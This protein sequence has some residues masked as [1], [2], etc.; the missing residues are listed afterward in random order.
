[1]IDQRGRAVILDFGLARAVSLGASGKASEPRSIDAGAPLSASESDPLSDQLTQEGALLGTPAYIPPE[2]YLGHAEDARGDQY[3]LCVALWEA[4]YGERPFQ[5]KRLG[6]LR[7]LILKGDPSPPADARVIPRWLRALLRRGLSV[8]RDARFPDVH[9][10]IAALER[11]RVRQ[12]RR[13]L[14]LVS[15]PMAL[16]LLGYL[17]YLLIQPGEV[18]LR[19]SWRG[20]PY[21]PAR[22]LVDGAPAD[23]PGGAL[24]LRPGLHRVTIDDPGFLPAEAIADVSA[25]ARHELA[26]TLQH[27][28]AIFELDVEPTG[29]SVFVDDV[30]YGSRL[31]NFA[32]DTGEHAIRVSKEGHY[33]QRFA[34]RAVAGE[35]H[36]RFVSLTRAVAWSRPVTGVNLDLRWLGDINGDGLDDLVI[37]AG[38]EVTYALNRNAEVF[39]QERTLTSSMVDGGAIPDRLA[40]TTVLFADMNGNGS[41]DVVWVTPGGQVTYLELFPV[42]PNLLSRVENGVG[43]VT[44]V[45]YGTSVEHMARDGGADAWPHRLPHPMIVV[46]GIDKWDRLTNVHEV[47][48]YRYH[49]GFYDGVEKRFRGYGRV[50]T[51]LLSD[52]TQEGGLTLEVYDVGADDP[53]RRGRLLSSTSWSA[54][55]ELSHSET[56]WDDCPVTGVAGA[57]PFASR[58]VCATATRSVQKEGTPEDRWA[59][60]ETAM[61][62]DGYGNVTLASD[63]GVTSI[64]GGG[65]APCERDDGVYGAPCGQD[66]HGDERFIETAYVSPDHTHGRWIVHAPY[67]V[68]RYG[69]A[70]D[71]L[72]SEVRTYYDGE[73]F[74]G[75]PLGELDRGEITRTTAKVDDAGAVISLRRF[76]Y[77]ADGNV[78]EA[79]DPLADPSGVTHRRAYT[80]D[81]DHLRVVAT[82]LLL[83]D[84]DGAPYRLRREV[85]YEPL[86]DMPV[87]ATS[88]MRVAGG[89]V[90][91]PR[92]SA[93][94]AYD[95][96]GRLVSLVRPGGDTVASPTQTYE[97]DLGA[98][99]SRVITRMRS[100]VGGP[101]DLELVGCVDGRGRA[102]QRRTR[103]A[104]DRYQVTGFTRYNPRSAPVQVY[105]PYIG[106]SDGCD[107][108]PPDGVPSTVTRYDAA[109]RP[110]ETTLPDGD[111]EG[112]ASVLR[113]RFEPLTTWVYDEE[114]DDPASPHHDTPT[115]IRSDGLG[116]TV[117]HDRYLTPD[118][119]ERTRVEFDA[120]GRV[121][122]YVDP[123]GN[124]KVQHY[125]L[126]GR[127]TS[128]HDPNA[129][130]TTF[131]WDDAGNLVAVVDGRGEEIDSRFDGL[132]RRVALWDPADPEA[133]EVRWR[134]DDAPGCDPG[135]C[136]NLE[137]QLASVTYPLAGLA[138]GSGEDLAGY[139]TRGRQVFSARTLAGA[140]FEIRASFDDADR[141]LATTFPDGRVIS[142]TLDDASRVSAVPGYVTAIGYDDR[143]QLADLAYDNGVHTSYA[144]DA[145][146]RRTEATTSGPT[147]PLQGF[148]YRRDRAGDLVAVEDTVR[149]GDVASAD[150][151]FT[152]D[153][154]Y[155]TTT[156]ALGPS[157]DRE[158][159]T[160]AFDA[161]DNVMSLTSSRG[162]ASGLVTG[163]FRYDSAAPNAV[164]E[165]AGRAMAYDAAGYMTSRGDTTLAWD[166]QGRLASA[167]RGGAE[168]ARF[169]YGPAHRRLVKVEDGSV[170]LYVSPGFELR[171]GI[172]SHY[173]SA[174]GQRVARIESADLAT[175]VLPDVAPLSGP[176]GEIDAGDAW[177]AW[178]SGADPTGH[179][180]SSARRML[181]ETQDEV[182]FLSG[183]HLGSLTL[184][185]DEAGAVVGRRAFYPTGADRGEGVG[186]VDFHGF[187][188]AERDASTGLLAFDVRY[189]DT[190]TGR[191]ISTDPLFRTATAAN[192][193]R[194]GEATSAYAYVANRWENLV[195]PTG[196]EGEAVHVRA[197]APKYAAS[198]KANGVKMFSARESQQ[199][200]LRIRPDG[201]IQQRNRLGIWRKYDSAAGG[202]L[203]NPDEK[204]QA[205]FVMNERGELF[206]TTKQKTG[207]VH[208]SSLLAGDAVAGAGMLV[209]TR[210]RLR[211]VSNSSGHY[212]PS[213]EMHTQVLRR[214]QELGVDMRR[215]ESYV[216]PKTTSSSHAAA[217]EPP[218]VPEPPAGGGYGGLASDY[219]G[220]AAP[221]AYEGEGSVYEP[222]VSGPYENPPGGGITYETDGATS[223]GGY[224]THP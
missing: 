87:E 163:A 155:R 174:A 170:T 161:L 80:Y 25:G 150:A 143:G 35:T 79:L 32:V 28:Q 109:H 129:G 169:V 119:F 213:H 46:D 140:R 177:V 212:S 1:M 223:G 131:T 141:L 116:R 64:G 133:S 29:G 203:H 12:L 216:D 75:L 182:T 15:V 105:E 2:R 110:I 220:L 171:D 197:V 91:S 113:T 78:V 122:G 183:D 180:W 198:D 195:D 160:A 76:A 3:S 185:T 67:Q 159:V 17:V 66:C 145:R 188:G 73:S 167:S 71:A 151:A 210:G 101:L 114:D 104:P 44:D 191:W 123:G 127:L 102:Y 224:Q 158:T 217:P 165:L 11:R 86:F 135:Q 34:W 72:A 196:L 18:V 94:Y 204:G 222:T 57:T 201:T 152:Y 144:F 168:V 156:S 175:R 96:F 120:L 51:E 69:R 52:E 10:L 139:D 100:Q 90:Q 50:E 27:E 59:V 53:Y 173:V 125:D 5:A 211:F 190:D 54:D 98:P 202:S 208:H 23:A 153:A 193:G 92:R 48:R 128:V 83:E 42:R 103:L 60:S 55:R 124:A 43:A 40:E 148:R 115:A 206:A 207:V 178:S 30:D 13:A 194:Y 85:Q 58:Y 126:A 19:A 138:G 215:V 187:T 166:Y 209:V 61:G 65:C 33:E 189:L 164:T 154:W 89:E 199:A 22:V 186:W 146:M 7:A 41:A 200:R 157:G 118:T 205:A 172:T 147:G 74:V 132:N 111:L 162:A 4:L 31:R 95:E 20:R 49:D 62:Y 221:G 137:G 184:A 130:D 82:D 99:A 93:F 97:Y 63:L 24:R 176:D 108:A 36:S 81:A 106:A 88:W 37:V 6:Y 214:L 16:T 14:T 219:G 68:R 142:R 8:D 117:A 218:S 192:L 47:T 112:G 9:A 134:Y 121:R 181:V 107:T 45:T 179:L 84:P 70:G 136:T 149:S 26:F 56:V 38:D 21:T 39:Q 77:D